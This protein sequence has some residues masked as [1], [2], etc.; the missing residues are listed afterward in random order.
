MSTDS[1]G[2]EGEPEVREVLTTAI[3][4]SAE[5][6]TRSHTC[7]VLIQRVL[8]VEMPEICG[9]ESFVNSM[10]KRRRFC[11]VTRCT[12]QIRS[13][14]DQVA[15]SLLCVVPCTAKPR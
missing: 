14:R 15:L 9:R 6:L 12:R 4:S 13:N 10:S 5:T 8:S 2:R 1:G 7:S 3:V 11:L